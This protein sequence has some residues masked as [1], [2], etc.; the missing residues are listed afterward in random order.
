MQSSLTTA[1]VS[2]VLPTPP[3]P[4]DETR[5]LG[6]VTAVDLPVESRS[7]CMSCCCAWPL[8]LK[9]GGSSGTSTGKRASSEWLP[10]LVPFAL[11]SVLGPFVPAVPPIKSK[12]DAK[13]IALFVSIRFLNRFLSSSEIS[14]PNEDVSFLNPF[15]PS[16]PSFPSNLLNAASGSL[17]CASMLWRNSVSM[18]S[19][20]LLLF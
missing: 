8:S 16:V 1:A 20:C 6:A 10:S 9:A 12:K 17:Y 14:I 4:C 13:S 3:I 2:M 11:V 7:A 5:L 18:S 19:Q 15:R